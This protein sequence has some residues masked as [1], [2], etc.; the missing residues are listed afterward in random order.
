M[1]AERWERATDI[2]AEVEEAYVAEGLSE[3]IS[4]RLSGYAALTVLG[5]QTAVCASAQQMGP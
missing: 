2:L 1:Y 5:R 3:E 4:D